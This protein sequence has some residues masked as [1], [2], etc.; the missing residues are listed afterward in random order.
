[1]KMDKKLSIS[2]YLLPRAL[3]LDPVEA[4]PPDSRLG[5]PLHPWQ[6]LDP[7]LVHHFECIAPNV[8]ISLQSGRS[9]RG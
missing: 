7:L 2:A 4:P 8:D 6:I 1:M 5:F 9:G 3:L